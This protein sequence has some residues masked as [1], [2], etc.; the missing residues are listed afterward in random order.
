MTDPA[1]GS[2][3][4]DRIL[5]IM[6]W[7]G[8]VMLV[9]GLVVALTWSPG[10]KRALTTNP[11]EGS[12]AFVDRLYMSDSPADFNAGQL[13]Q[14]VLRA[15][16]VLALS[17]RSADR[18]PRRGTWT[19][20]ETVVPFPVSEVLPSWNLKTPPGTGAK[21]HLRTRDARS[22][23]WSPWLYLGQ[24][25]ESWPGDAEEWS[26][27]SFE[28]GTVHVDILVLDRPADA[29]QARV[30]LYAFTPEPSVT[31]E[32][33]RVAVCCSGVVPDSARRESLQPRVPVVTGW[34]RDLRVPFRAQG[35]A[36]EAL[37]SSICSPTS[38]TMVMAHHGV[39]RPTVENAAA[40]YDR[41]HGIFGNWGRAVA[42]AGELGLNA[43]LTRFRN[44]EQVK[45]AI[46]GGQP[47]VAAIKFNKGE[48]PS[49]LYPD[50]DGHLVVIR[51]FTP[52]GD[53]IVNDP[54]S[55][56]KGNG[57]VYKAAELGRAWFDNA[58]GVAYVIAR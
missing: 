13:D 27:T 36:P 55:R 22:G 23:R 51:G 16:G 37:R 49:A 33:R 11:L 5:R 29:F 32:V 34:A 46:A 35:D 26:V 10:R 25:G 38:V 19:G 52:E 42:R 28:Q 57:V 4:P 40:I 47:V 7:T 15:E 31:P 21:L 56:E 43:W 12:D 20:P 54:A 39:D 30:T 17:D 3:P 58:G 24:W 8:A 1:A 50:T 44:W 14:L 2:V 45:A 9:A 53:V 18:F 41:E 6:A 48:F